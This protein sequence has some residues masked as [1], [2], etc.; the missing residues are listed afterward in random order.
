M[1]S[2]LYTHFID[3]GW[4]TACM[5][6][7]REVAVETRSELLAFEREEIDKHLGDPLCLNHNRP[8]ITKEEKKQHDKEYGKIR[9]QVNREREHERVAEWRRNNPELRAEQIRRSVEQQRQKRMSA[10]ENDL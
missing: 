4:D 3:V 2:P 5:T 9:R 6:A 8:V 1:N 10:K 7:I